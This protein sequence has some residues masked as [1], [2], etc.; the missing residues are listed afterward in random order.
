MLLRTVWLPHRSDDAT[1]SAL[2]L[3]ASRDSSNADDA[4][5]TSVAVWCGDRTPPEWIPLL[6]VYALRETSQSENLSSW[7]MIDWKLL[8][9][10]QIVLSDIVVF[11]QAGLVARQAASELIHWVFDTD[12]VTTNDEVDIHQRRLALVRGSFEEDHQLSH[13][14]RQIRSVRR[15]SVW[16]DHETAVARAM[17]LDGLCSPWSSWKRLSV[18]VFE[19]ITRLRHSDVRPSALWYANPVFQRSPASTL[20]TEKGVVPWPAFSRFFDYGLQLG[21]IIS[22]E[23]RNVTSEE[24]IESIGAFVVFIEYTARDIVLEERHGSHFGVSKSVGIVGSLSATVATSDEVLPHIN[25]LNAVVRLNGVPVASG[26]TRGMRHSFGEMISYASCGETLLPGDLLC[27]WKLV[28]ESLKTI[29]YSNTDAVFLCQAQERYPGHPALKLA[30]VWG[31]LLS[32]P[33]S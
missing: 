8:A 24:A 33:M 5:A 20:L 23:T 28:C 9:R 13:L 18:R 11:L 12:A 29:R 16:E 25:N 6:P 32:H 21:V 31:T 3:P 4:G 1:A 19:A 14:T 26:N 30:D 7:S 10:E 2:D 27:T 22:K 15:F 17:L